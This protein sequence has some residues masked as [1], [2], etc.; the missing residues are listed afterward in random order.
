MNSKKTFGI[1]VSCL[2]ILGTFALLGCEKNQKDSPYNQHIR[3]Y[4]KYLCP[5]CENDPELRKT[6]TKCGQSGIVFQK[7]DIA[8]AQHLKEY[9]P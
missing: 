6:C 9:K 3:Q 5:V 4:S 8:K 1:I 2:F 7:P